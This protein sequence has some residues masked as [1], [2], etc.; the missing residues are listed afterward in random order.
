[1]PKRPSSALV[2][3]KSMNAD[4]QLD[5]RVARL[6]KLYRMNAPDP[7][8]EKEFEL[9]RK[10]G[11]ASR[12]KHIALRKADAALEKELANKAELINSRKIKTIN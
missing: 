10:A 9:I 12:K 5:M 3:M 11:E 8:I 7:I 1:M 2:Q 6:K 4:L